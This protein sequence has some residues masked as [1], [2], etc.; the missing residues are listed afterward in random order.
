MDI[1]NEGMN[2]GS[3][4]PVTVPDQTL[5]KQDPLAS[6]D[7]LEGYN[8][9]N[10]FPKPQ[11]VELSD[12][13]E[14]EDDIGYRDD[15]FEESG[16]SDKEFPYALL[17]SK[18]ESAIKGVRLDGSKLREIESLLKKSDPDYV[19]YSRLKKVKAYFRKEDLK[20]EKEKKD[21]PYNKK[22]SLK[23]SVLFNLTTG[24]EDVGTFH[25][26]VFNKDKFVL[27]YN[28]S[29]KFKKYFSLYYLHIASKYG[30][31]L[32]SDNKKLN[33][34]LTLLEK[35]KKV[36]FESGADT[37]EREDP[38]PEIDVMKL[39]E[40]SG[41]DLVS[42]DSG[43][44]AYQFESV[45][46]DEFFTEAAKIDEDIKDIIKTLNEKGY[47]TLYSCSG[48]P[49][50]WSKDDVYRDGVKN[51]KLYSSARIV[52]AEAYP[53]PNIPNGW[54]KKVMDNDSEKTKVGIYVKAPTFNI[55][56]GLPKDQFYAWKKKYMYHLQKWVDE[57][58]KKDELSSS[59]NAEVAVES[60]SITEVLGDLMISTMITD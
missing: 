7:S 1:M 59:D 35:G 32:D 8:A 27:R 17:H 18:K 31:V 3:M 44:E 54:K 9:L 11:E 47:E 43:G 30:A 22:N 55:V 60:A 49:S 4:L 6:D 12:D 26:L 13:E 53:F 21:S 51:D 14:T 19:P 41:V 34:W 37:E 23:K 45:D 33:K 46:D 39:L 29:T 36:V 15:D 16:K 2:V 48:H 50:A 42:Y 58:P 20:K 57:L 25:V 56:K 38:K 5:K 28:I 40:E 10:I 52:F 24:K